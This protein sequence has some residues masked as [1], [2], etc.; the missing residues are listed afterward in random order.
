MCARQCVQ[1]ME[2]KQCPLPQYYLTVHEHCGLHGTACT[3]YITRPQD[4][5]TH[6][7]PNTLQGRSKLFQDAW[8]GQSVHI[9]HVVC[10]GIWG[11][12]PTRKLHARK[13]L[14][15]PFLDP[16]SHVLQTEFQ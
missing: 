5:D 15:G 13:T 4:L 10:R 11:H 7:L 3:R 2:S 9:L 1:T 6:F 16:K 12:A 8:C 14:L